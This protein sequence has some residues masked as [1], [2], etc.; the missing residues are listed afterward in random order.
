MTDRPVAVDLFCGAGGFSRGLEDAG[1]EIIC[2]VDSDASAVETYEY[3]LDVDVVQDPVQ[4]LDPDDVG[5][6]NQDIDLIVGSPPCP[7]FST[8]GRSKIDSFEDRSYTDDERHNLYEDFIR[9]IRECRPQT[10]VMENVP[11]MQTAE[12]VAGRR[13]VE[14]IKRQMET[15]DYSVD[16]QYPDAA[17]FGVP[18]HR[19]RAIFLG[20]RLGKENPKLSRWESHRE[21]QRPAEK[22]MKQRHDAADSVKQ[23]QMTVDQF[24]V[25]IGTAQDGFSPQFEKHRVSKKPWVTVAD[26]IMDLP[27]VSPAG[28]KPPT[29]IEE[30]TIPP[31]SEYQAWAREWSDSEEIEGDLYNHECRGHNMRDL[32]LYKLLGEGVGWIIGD[33]DEEY[34]P[35]RTDIFSDN[36]RKQKPDEPAST[37]LAHIHKDGNQYIHPREARSLTVREV[38]RLQSFRDSF[39][40]PVSRT[41]AYRQVGNAVPPLLAQAIGTAIRSEV[42]DV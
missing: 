17:N 19:K 20:N 13:V 31:V 10:F 42:F 15:L 21:P 6:D 30:Y 26:A 8:I 11:G 40:F 37:I 23:D 7:T 2:A 24:G 28:E 5:I 34:Q 4:E 12:N 27:P 36:Y 22:L 3:N 29:K 38:A 1:F 35:Y 33:I 39:D 41:Q 14:I 18:Q 25:D 9:F 32:T 16:V